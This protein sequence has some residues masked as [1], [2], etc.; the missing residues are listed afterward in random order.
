MKTI[1]D[2]SLIDIMP[3]SISRDKNVASAATAIDNQLRAL[4]GY[5]DIG[6]LI[7]NIDRLPGGVLDHMAM[8]YD[9]SVW[10]DSWSVETKRSVLKNSLSDKRKRGTRG[11]VVAALASLGSSASI[12]EWWQ[13]SPRGTPHTFKIYATL[14]KTG[15]IDA[16]VQE[17]LIK[18]IDDAKP[19]RSH[20]DFILQQSVDGGVG[21][22]A[23]IRPLTVA[24]I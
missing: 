8:Q 21:V 23:Y 22:C 2:V 5:V 6:T 20:Y 14:P 16:E 11:A 13:E 4:A 19:L 12:V 7:A 10:R 18:M 17:D 1:D 3:G 24:R 9:V 15:G